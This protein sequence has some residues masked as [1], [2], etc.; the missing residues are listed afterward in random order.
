[1][2]VRATNANSQITSVRVKL[3]V[4]EVFHL[5][6]LYHS[7]CLSKEFVHLSLSLIGVICTHDS[8]GNKCKFSDHEYAGKAGCGGGFSSPSF[9]P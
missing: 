6:H 4:V 5:H 8:T 2:I 3:V 9:L 7:Q 1:M